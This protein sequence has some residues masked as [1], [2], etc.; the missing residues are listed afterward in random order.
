MDKRI[1]I[2]YSFEERITYSFWKYFFQSCGVWVK[3]YKTGDKIPLNE[4]NYQYM[5]ILNND[6]IREMKMISHNAVYVVKSNSSYK[7]FRKLDN[8]CAF[9]WRK[10]QSYYEI[11]DKLF[12]ENSVFRE[13][14]SIYIDRSLWL[15]AWLYHEIPYDEK[16]TWREQIQIECAK[17]LSQLE[18]LDNKYASQKQ[19]RF[20]IEYMKLYCNF[21]IAGANKTNITEMKDA[22]IGLL[23][24][25]TLLA[26]SYEWTLSLLILAAQVSDLSALTSVHII[27]YL[28]KACEMEKSAGLLY[29]IGRI[30]ERL[31][32]KQDVAYIY[33]EASVTQDRFYYRTIYKLALRM[34]DQ[35]EW[36]QAIICYRNIINIL[37]DIMDGN[38]A[39]ISEIE[40][41]YKANRHLAGIFRE[42]LN[43]SEIAG[44]YEQNIHSL[45]KH[46]KQ[47]GFKKLEHCM[48]MASNTENMQ[49]IFERIVEILDAR[50]K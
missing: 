39:S 21:L 1:L 45:Q 3:A 11:V 19:N 38:Y 32:G 22:N 28:R 41:L 23:S 14:L 26:K 5:Y 49:G 36:F 20:Y 47:E 48:H 30:Y 35:Q 44:S 33:Y 31:Y 16:D 7:S 9:Q 24:E 50:L 10:R 18:L 25:I 6:D 12:G 17:A 8:I 40:Y 37:P 27:E 43:N 42:Q 34:E 13:L 2:A 46:I 4:K 29:D 15:N